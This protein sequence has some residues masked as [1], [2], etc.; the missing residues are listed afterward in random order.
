MH[1]V[2]N[3]NPTRHHTVVESAVCVAVR[4]LAI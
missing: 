2:M 3:Y 1:V 4:F